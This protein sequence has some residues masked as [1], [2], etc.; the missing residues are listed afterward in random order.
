MRFAF[1]PAVVFATAL[2]AGCGK[3]I[4]DDC[5]LNIDCDPDGLRTCDLASPN[6]YCTI[7]GCTFDSCPEESVCISFYIASFE[8]RPCDPYAP[9][10]VCG[11][12]EVCTLQGQCVPSG[13]EVRYCMKTCESNDDCRDQY[14]CRGEELMRT[15]GGQP[16]PPDGQGLGD[17]LQAFCAAAPL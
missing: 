13:A 3:E 9:G 6:G 7:P 12:D 14:E 1:M 11:I 4:G 5:T 10:D 15:H 17:D 2:A 16:V 8:N